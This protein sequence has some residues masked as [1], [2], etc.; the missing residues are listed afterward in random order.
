MFMSNRSKLPNALKH[1]AFAKVAILPG[2]DPREFEE[3]HFGL[4]EEWRPEGPTEEDAVLAIANGIWRKRRVQK[5][6]EARICRGKIDS[7]HP[8][9]DEA[10]TLCILHEI[11]ATDPD[12]F[13][14]ALNGLSDEQADHLRSKFPRDSFKSGSAW[15]QAVQQEIKSVLLPAAEDYR[16]MPAVVLLERSSWILSEDDL[17]RE[18]AVDERIDL[19]I[20]RAIKRLIQTKTMKQLVDRNSTM[21]ITSKR[22]RAVRLRDRQKLNALQ[23]PDG[24]WG[25]SRQ[26][27]RRFGSRGSVAVYMMY[28]QK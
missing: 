7:N 19:A 2:E 5:F 10:R 26:T 13:D 9:Y 21:A 27:A 28:K 12:S 6:R 20:E 3:L 4:I 23:D 1:G 18:L 17:D 16:R 24:R 15:V 11:L 14:Q 22:T 8:A 25:P